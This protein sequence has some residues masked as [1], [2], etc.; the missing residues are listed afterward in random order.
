[1]VVRGVWPKEEEEEDEGEVEEAEQVGK[2]M[3][4]KHI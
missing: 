1:V 4:Q 3:I 2:T